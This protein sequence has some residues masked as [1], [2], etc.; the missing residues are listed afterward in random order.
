MNYNKPKDQLEIKP[1]SLEQ[2]VDDAIQEMVKEKQENPDL[3]IPYSFLDFYNQPEM[4]NLLSTVYE[5][6]KSL[7]SFNSAFLVLKKDGN[8]K[9]SASF[10]DRESILLTKFGKIVAKKYGQLILKQKGMISSSEDQNFYETIIYFII[11]VIKSSTS[12]EN[13][14]LIE[15]EL[16]R[17]FR[18]TAF[19]FCQRKKNEKG[20]ETK[21]TFNRCHEN[22]L[23]IHKK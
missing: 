3:I 7:I 15:D 2:S 5:Y 22:L 18:S 23:V 11:K 6:S 21:V 8:H 14:D 12:S 10:S 4:L 13:W 17:L 1:F 20:G 16:N 19:N 9:E